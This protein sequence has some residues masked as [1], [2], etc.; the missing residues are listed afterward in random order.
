MTYEQKCAM[1]FKI[2]RQLDILS[3]KYQ[4]LCL[5]I[6]KDESKFEKQKESK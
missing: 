3:E 6:A 5:D 2:R 1:A 4:L